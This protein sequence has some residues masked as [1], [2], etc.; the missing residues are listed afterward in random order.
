MQLPT[1]ILMRAKAQAIYNRLIV[2]FMDVPGAVSVSHALAHHG[3]GDLLSLLAMSKSDMD[4]LTMPPTMGSSSITN[5][6]I[7]EPV[8]H[9]MCNK[10]K[11]LLCW[12]HGKMVNGEL[13]T[14]EEWMMLSADDFYEVCLQCQIID[15]SVQHLVCL[16]S[17]EGEISASLSHIVITD[18]DIVNMP[19]QHAG[20][21]V[22]Q[23]QGDNATSAES[24]TKS[25]GNREELSAEPTMEISETAVTISNNGNV[26]VCE[27]S[28]NNMDNG[29]TSKEEEEDDAMRISDISVQLCN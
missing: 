16:A 21:G 15:P 9:G 24:V 27:N 5:A 17:P 28:S 3:F 20:S 7:N 25:N 26:Y 12:L 10:L 13:Q 6:T 4:G 22:I 1:M 29:S 19:T 18:D 8:S 23:T 14:A 2:D 11:K